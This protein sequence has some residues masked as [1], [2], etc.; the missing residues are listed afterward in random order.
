MPTGAAQ[1]Q[2]P[3]RS[4][5]CPKNMVYGPCGGVR[6]DGRCEVA[7]HPC[8]F[9]DDPPQH[10]SPLAVPRVDARTVAN[11]PLSAGPASS[12]LE[13]ARERPVVLTDLT[14][15]PFDPESVHAVT[16]ALAGSCDAVLVG[17][18]S[19][20]PDLPP[21]L[22]AAE[23]RAAGGVPWVTLT[24]RDR[25]RVVLETELGGLAAVLPERGIDGVLCVTGD[26]RA[27]RAGEGLA[28]VCALGGPGLAALAA[29][30]G[31]PVALAEPPEAE[32]VPSR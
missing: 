10:W 23:V 31:L 3:Q 16:R 25:N 14:V 8:T 32:P 6:G 19:N 15:R 12:L 30:A 7:E 26:A 18:H 29:P 21:T 22:M 1:G 11:S 5:G 2:G 9:L 27:P 24:C 20:R 17:E 28:Q 13:T 4:P